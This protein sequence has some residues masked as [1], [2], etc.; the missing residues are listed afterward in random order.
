MARMDCDD[1]QSDIIDCAL[2]EVGRVMRWNAALHLAS[3][4]P[5]PSLAHSVLTPKL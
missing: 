3:C 1:V 2:D 5:W 4:C